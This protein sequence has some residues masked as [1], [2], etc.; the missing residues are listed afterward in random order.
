MSR[1]LKFKAAHETG[2]VGINNPDKMINVCTHTDPML[3]K[4]TVLISYPAYSETPDPETG[5]PVSVLKSEEFNI[6]QIE[7]T[8]AEEIL[9]KGRLEEELQKLDAELAAYPLFIEVA[10]EAL[11]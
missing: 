4:S 8:Y 7:R 2:N 9:R 11:A 1:L 10:K 3:A 6:Q 5:L